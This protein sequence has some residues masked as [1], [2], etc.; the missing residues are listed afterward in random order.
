MVVLANAVSF[1]TTA[2]YDHASPASSRTRSTSYV[3]PRR[4]SMTTTFHKQKKFITTCRKWTSYRYAPTTVNGRL[5]PTHTSTYKAYGLSMECSGCEGLYLALRAEDR[6]SSEP[7]LQNSRVTMAVLI[8]RVVSL[9]VIMLTSGRRAI[10]RHGCVKCCL[11]TIRLG[12]A[13]SE[14]CCSQPKIGGSSCDGRA[15]CAFQRGLE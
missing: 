11:S 13:C 6:R 10:A 2:C 7:E 5:L 15:A 4:G 3:I 8:V 12:R 1:D 9:L 14:S